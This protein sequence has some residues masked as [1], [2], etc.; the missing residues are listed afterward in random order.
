MKDKLIPKRLGK[1]PLVEAVCELRFK[2]DKDSISDLL[3]G[4]IFQKL[5]DKFP[6]IE[7]LPAS[8]LPPVVLKND[9]DL[10][11]APTVKLIGELYSIMLGEHICAVSSTRPYS[12]WD[13][14]S[15]MITELLKILNDTSLITHPERISLKY[16]DILPNKDGFMLDALN[17]DIQI[18]DHHITTAPF[19]LRTEINDNEFL[20]VIQI[21]SPAHTILRTGERLSGILIDI[22]II[23]RSMP[24]DFW[25][26]P[27]IFLDK[28]HIMGKSK[29]FDILKT[30]TIRRLDPE[31]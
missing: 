21:A 15:T 25:E 16:I 6:K 20:G 22:D 29:F 19:Q 13:Q 4:L 24:D 12:G 2:S 7:K 31:I 5:R 11:Y 10:R 26:K 18:G 1:E 3:P 28:A 8:N 14:F 27:K 17:L 9:P 30:E 23:S